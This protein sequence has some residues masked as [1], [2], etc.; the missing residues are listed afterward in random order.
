MYRHLYVAVAA[1]LFLCTQPAVAQPDTAFNFQG[2]L[3]H[4]GAPANGQFDFQFRLMD[5]ETG[6]TQIGPTVEQDGIAVSNGQFSTLLDFGLN[7]FDGTARW[8]ETSVRVAGG[9]TFDTLAPRQRVTASP[10]ALY[11]QTI[12]LA[13]S[14]S[15][16]TAARSDHHH[17]GQNWTGSTTDGLRVSNIATTAETAIRGALISTQENATAIRGEVAAESGRGVAG[18]SVGTSGPGIGVYGETRSPEGY[19]GYFEGGRNYFEGPVG[20]GTTTPRQ[21]LSLG[22]FLDLYSG[23]VNNP[24]RSSVRGTSSN[25][26]MLNAGGGGRTYLNHDSGTGGLRIHDGTPS[27]EL[28]RVT[29]AGRVGIG[30]TNPQDDL[31]VTGDIRTDGQVVHTYSGAP[32]GTVT[33]H[34]I[35]RWNRIIGDNTNYIFFSDDNIRLAIRGETPTGFLRQRVYI[36]ISPSRAAAANSWQ[37]TYGESSGGDVSTPTVGNWYTLSNDFGHDP[38]GGAIYQINNFRIRDVTY[39]VSAHNVSLMGVHLIV[40]AFY[41]DDPH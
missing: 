34:T 18:I 31:H 24:I 40:E 32:F 20:L 30:V 3:T 9:A 41:S 28:M 17:H 27:G 19:A 12:P 11:A 1:A 16:T 8:V 22:H 4:Q 14:G 35:R 5:A 29:G 7:A 15:A 21:Q 39:R 6:G 23:A 26:L 10:F 2:R 13:G 25:H 36:R 37:V 33:R 38:R